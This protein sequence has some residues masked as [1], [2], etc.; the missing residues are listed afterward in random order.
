MSPQM[1]SDRQ[2]SEVSCNASFPYAFAG[3]SSV[4]EICCDLCLQSGI[5]SVVSLCSAEGMGFMRW[6][7]GLP[8]PLESCRP[9]VLGALRGCTEPAL[10]QPA[11]ASRLPDAALLSGTAAGR[12]GPEETALAKPQS[13]LEVRLAADA[14]NQSLSS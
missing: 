12:L 5:G 1:I 14:S 8:T 13:A 4:L 6:Q 10:P 3:R 9:A 7:L 11:P 2:F